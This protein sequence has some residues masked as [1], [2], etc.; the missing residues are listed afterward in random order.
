MKRR[1]LGLLKTAQYARQVGQL[2]RDHLKLHRT[3]VLRA[4]LGPEL[5]FH[6]RCLEFWRDMKDGFVSRAHAEFLYAMLTAWGMNSRKAQLEPFQIFWQS[7]KSAQRLISA[8]QRVTLLNAKK[9]D[10]D[11]LRAL[12]S[13]LRVTN[14]SSEYQLVGKAKVLAHLLPHW[15]APIDRAH[16]LVFLT[17]V[18]SMSSDQGDQWELFC[19]IHEK[20][21]APVA[22]RRAKALALW[23]QSASAYG[24]DSSIPK[25]IDN[26]IWAVPRKRQ[27][28]KRKK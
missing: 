9:S 4:K 19:D 6:V 12:W 5:H 23:I 15:I 18:Q 8:L 2:V 20:C 1:K 3:F 7:L 11:K 27:I 10:W 13:D 25:T 24:W 26:L 21:F 16:T 17:G 28:K 22:R 14:S